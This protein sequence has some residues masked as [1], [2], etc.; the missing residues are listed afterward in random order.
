MRIHIESLIRKLILLTLIVSIFWI[1]I[2]KIMSIDII[3]V[4]LMDW[5]FVGIWYLY[6]II[7]II[8][9]LFAIVVTSVV[10]YHFL[11]TSNYLK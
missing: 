3:H 11:I 10:I 5:V 1:T 4:I 6:I 7:I 2:K 9:I 8:S